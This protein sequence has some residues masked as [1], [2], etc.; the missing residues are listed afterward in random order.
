MRPFYGISE[1]QNS[2]VLD[3]AAIL[4]AHYV[5]HRDRDGFAGSH[6]A[7]VK[8]VV[9]SRRPEAQPHGITSR[10]E[11]LHDEVKIGER[12]PKGVDNLFSA[13]LGLDSTY[14]QSADVPRSQVTSTRR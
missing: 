12:V 4:N 9:R 11:V 6:A 14:A 7:H 8:A 2:P 13:P 5:Y 3:D 1:I 10:R